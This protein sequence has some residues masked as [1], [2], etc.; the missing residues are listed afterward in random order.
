[1]SPNGANGCRWRFHG[2][3]RFLADGLMVVQ[4]REDE[5]LKNKRAS[6]IRKIERSLQKCDKLEVARR[7]LLSGILTEVALQLQ[8]L[9]S[10]EKQNQLKIDY[11]AEV[12]YTTVPQCPQHSTRTVPT[13]RRHDALPCLGGPD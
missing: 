1:M 2:L 13:V 10:A 3:V 5:R 12:R 6:G 11:K 7:P 4:A 9:L 8:R